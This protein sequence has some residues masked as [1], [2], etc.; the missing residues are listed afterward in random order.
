MS[1]DVVLN[2]VLSDSSATQTNSFQFE[3]ALLDECR[4]AM[5]QP[6]SIVFT[7]GV[8]WLVDTSYTQDFPAFIDDKGGIG[9]AKC[10]IKTVEL[11]S[12]KPSF[13]TLV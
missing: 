2:G 9:N 6:Q 11:D 5:I 12:D 4:D 1:E 13:L 7:S 3:L 10:G 8:V